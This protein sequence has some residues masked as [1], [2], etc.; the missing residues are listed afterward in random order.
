MANAAAK[1]AKAARQSASSTYLL[2]IIILNAI[3]VV[4][5]IIY[6][7]NTYTKYQCV[8]SLLLFGLTAFA[9]NGIVENYAT[10]ASQ[11][12]KSGG[13]T[14]LAGGESLDL[15]ALVVV[16]QLGSALWSDGFLWLLGLLPP[17]GAWKLYG[18]YNGV[19]GD[20]GSGG[21][22]GGNEGSGEEK[23]EDEELKER[24]RKRADKRRAKWS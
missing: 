17:W 6:H 14:A 8:A 23:E 3:Y 24:R 16:V 2:P 10:A 4:I 18:M 13:S 1:K 7:W 9:Y 20:S 5:R 15:L 11:S 22:F 19:S 21:L 12:V